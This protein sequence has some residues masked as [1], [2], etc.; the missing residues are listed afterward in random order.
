[1]VPFESLDA[2]FYSPSIVTM[3]LS[4]IMSDIKRYIWQ[5]SLFWPRDAMYK[6]GLSRH[7]LSACVSVTI[8]DHVK[9]NTHIYTIFFKGK[10][11]GKGAYSC[12]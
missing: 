7:A 2:V 8:V 10:R 6:H 3:V 12:S 11:K 9:T 4:Y 1:M 5:T